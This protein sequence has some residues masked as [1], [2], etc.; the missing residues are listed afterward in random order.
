MA[1][2]ARIKE[3]VTADGY[4]VHEESMEDYHKRLK[5]EDAATKVKLAGKL[6]WNSSEQGTYKKPTPVV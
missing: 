3:H 2:S 6:V 1:N 5:E 4:T